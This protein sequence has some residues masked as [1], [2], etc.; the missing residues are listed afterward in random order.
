[1]ILVEKRPLS[2][3]KINVVEKLR[4]DCGWSG[5]AGDTIHAM[6]ID[7]I[8]RTPPPIGDGYNLRC[9]ACKSKVKSVRY[10]APDANK[11]KG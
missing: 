4:C 11:R 6:W 9:P 7:P 8:F 1:M 10:T 5:T 3:P 2:L